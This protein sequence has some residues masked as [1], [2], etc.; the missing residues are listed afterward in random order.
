MAQR[1]LNSLLP[2]TSLSA[3]ALSQQYAVYNS[4]TRPMQRSLPPI[5]VNKQLLPSPQNPCRHDL[6]PRQTSR[7]YNCCNSRGSKR[8]SDIIPIVRC[9]VTASEDGETRKMD[10]DNLCW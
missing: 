6:S 2:M 8:S 5:M 4:N 10:W 1:R 7:L 9:S 3:L